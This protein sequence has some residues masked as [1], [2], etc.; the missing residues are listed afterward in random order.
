MKAAMILAGACAALLAAEAAAQTPSAAPAPAAAPPP[1]PAK[2]AGPPP[3]P[4]PPPGWPFPGQP[5]EYLPKSARGQAQ[6]P[7]FPE[8][9][10]APYTPSKVR[11]QVNTVADGLEYPWGLAF[12]PDGRM[13]VTERPGR[14]RIVSGHTLSPPIAGLP[15]VHTQAISGMLDVVIDPHFVSNHMIYWTYV[16]ARD[17]GSGVTLAKGRL[18]DGPAPRV[19]DVKVIYRQ[20]PDLVTTHSNYGGRLVFGRDGLLYVT[21]GDRDEMQWR[22]L[23]QRLDTGV[24][25]VIRIDTNGASPKDNP[26]VGQAGALPELWALGFR[27]PIGMS[28][29]PGTHE[30]WVADVGPRGGDEI[31]IVKPGANYG[32]PVIGYGQEYSGDRVGEGT[33]KDGM[34]QPAYYWDPVISPSSVMFYDGKLFPA[35]RGSAFVTS[36]TQQHLV[37]LAMKGDKAVG[38][39]R[40]LADLKERLREVKQGPDGSLYI[41]TDNAK[42]RILQLTPGG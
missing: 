13:L 21:L 23:I 35:W 8:Q 14:I 42:G 2:R 4:P 15:E 37:R 32:W 19:E 28:W 10:R 6:T 26:F 25:K 33:A 18:V 7:A 31:D 29:R 3:P 1:A 22:P 27:N 24:G 9:T 38:E 40:L 30:L 41:L 12:L 16:E 39:E 36:L 11:F 20:K 17:T 5:V 34:E